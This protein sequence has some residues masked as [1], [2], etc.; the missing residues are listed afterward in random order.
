MLRDVA[1]AVVVYACGALGGALG[2]GELASLA[3]ASK[4][5]RDAVG[6]HGV[7]RAALGSDDVE[8]RVRGCKA[9]A[10][11]ALARAGEGEDEREEAAAA[12]EST[13]DAL[14]GA[15]LRDGEARVRREAARALWVLRGGDVTPERA[16]ALAEALDG[17]ALFT[18]EGHGGAV[19]SVCFSPDGKQLASS[20][21]DRTV[22]LWDVETGAC[23]RTLE[24][25]SKYVSSVCFS[26]DGR[27]L[28]SSSDDN[29]VRLWDVE[30]GACVKTLE[31]HDEE[32]M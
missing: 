32:V 25:H 16:K 21:F 31:G 27:R 26:P 19:Y 30:A 6:P 23:V 18:L 2:I 20:S 4:V 29:M 14:L 12:R 8:A 11:E 15:L 17:E 10:A 22:R 7:V 28:A 24:G 3:C 1:D 5:W 9:V 13:F